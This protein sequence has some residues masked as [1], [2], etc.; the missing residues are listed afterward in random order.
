MTNEE[1]IKIIELAIAEVEWNYP[2]DYAAA[3]NKAI[4]ALRVVDKLDDKSIINSK[5][6]G[7]VVVD[8]LK[9]KELG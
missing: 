8:L 1:A 2:V 3:F 4:E 5:R 9:K 7:F 6:D